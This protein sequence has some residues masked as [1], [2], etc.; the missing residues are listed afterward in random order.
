MSA[1]AVRAAKPLDYD[2]DVKPVLEAR[3][4]KCH[5]PEKQKAGL[6]L[7]VKESALKGGESGEPAI[8]PGNALKSHL[9]KLVMSNDPA[10]FMPPKGERLTMAEVELIKQWVEEGAHWNSVASAAKP[11]EIVQVEAEAPITDA[12]RQ[13]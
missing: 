6:R 3:C 4:F 7:D 13:W 10:E 12:D 5:G 8:V 2:K 1:G 9:L 11:V